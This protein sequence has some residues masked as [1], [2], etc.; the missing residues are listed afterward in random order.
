MK[1]TRLAV[2]MMSLIF[3]CALFAIACSQA[4]TAA[5]SQDASEAK[6][7]AESVKAANGDVAK[8]AKESDEVKEEVMD[9]SRAMEEGLRAAEEKRRAA[10]R[11]NDAK[12]EEGTPAKKSE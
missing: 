2:V 6:E 12:G 8:E 7:S 4:T 1:K 11:I 9:P 5:K 10:E 3:A